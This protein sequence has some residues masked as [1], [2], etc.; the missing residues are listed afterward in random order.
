MAAKAGRSASSLTRLAPLKYV[1]VT[2]S[3]TFHYTP[4]DMKMLGFSRIR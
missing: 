1:R 3:K 4:I 2:G